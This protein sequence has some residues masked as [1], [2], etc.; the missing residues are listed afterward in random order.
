VRP[1][2][3]AAVVVLAGA[4]VAPH[5]VLAAPGEPPPPPPTPTKCGPCGGPPLPPTLL[6]TAPIAAMA[7]TYRMEVKPAKV[8]RGKAL[9]ISVVAPADDSWAASIAYLHQ[10][11]VVCARYTHGSSSTVKACKIAKSAPLGKASL[12][13]QFTEYHVDGHITHPTALTGPITVVK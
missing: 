10:K 7:Q 4:L 8:H 9:K 3:T 1:A 6:P 5:K 11:Y 12:R 13:V 2:F